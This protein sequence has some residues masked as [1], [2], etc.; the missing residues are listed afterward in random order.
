[1][2]RVVAL[3]AVLFLAA[4]V[5]FLPVALEDLDSV[6][7]A[8]GVRDFDVAQH[9]PHPPGYPAFIALAK[10]STA[11][12]SAAGVAMPDVRGLALLSAIAGALLIP[13]I[14]VF[15]RAVDG[16]ELRSV[17]TTILA[18]CAP[19]VWFNAVRPL[20]DMAG[21]AAAFA[22]LAALGPAIA[23]RPGTLPPSPALLIAGAFLAGLA[24]GFRSQMCLL[25]V[26][27]LIYGIVRQR[28]HRTGMIAAAIAGVL[29][30]GVPLVMLNGGPAGYL[31][32]LGSQAGED[33]S[34]VVMLWTNPSPR[35]AV[36]A[37]LHT[38]VRPWDA[39]WLAGV[40]LSLGAAGVLVLLRRRPRTFAILML[41]FGPYAVFHLLFQE[42][43]T[44]RYA[45][46]LVPLLACLAA[47]AIAESRTPVALGTVSVLAV[48]SLSFAMPAATA[49][50]K[51]P[52]PVFGLL[53]EAQMLHARGAAP[54]VGMHRRVFTESRRA[55]TYAGDPP[56][57]L[58]PTPRDYEWLE[59]TRSWREG[60]A[61]SE[62]WFFA[63][64][65]RTDLALVDSAHARVREYRWPFNEATYVGGARPSAIDWHVLTRP[66]WFLEQGWALTP[67]TAGIAD[68]DGWGP[69]RKPS[70]GWIRRRAAE[71]VMVIGGRHLGADPPVRLTASID[72][73]AVATLEVKP[74]YFLEFITVPAGELLGTGAYAPL[75]VTAEASGAEAS[76]PVSI[77]QFDFQTSD[78][79]LFGYDEGWF[80]P[81]FNPRTAR[82]WRWTSERATVRIHHAGRNVTLRFAGESP[83]RYFDQP[84]LVR[85][86]AGDRVLAELRPAA[87]FTVDVPIPADA[88][89][90]AQGRI[91]ITTDRAFVAGERTGT[92][93]RRRLSLRVYSLSVQ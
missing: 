10:A 19:L 88:L 47:A 23:L 54:I 9:Q 6:N 86:T 35:V 77:E 3:L 30:W 18:A 89:T 65:Q 48:V 63:D 57:Q 29:A 39:P 13:L 62:A 73:R 21:L 40:M 27:V 12:L 80:E 22:A 38:F 59:L 66:G 64:P 85:V 42:T 58:L 60:H 41:T 84:P 76:P 1:V 31:R 92:A 20:S 67:E 11:A 81:E 46:P 93:D 83:L 26:P 44:T 55:R 8:M 24:G 5:P 32:A 68:R 71:S 53:S 52:S 70:V 72:A 87:D 7:F 78:S 82:S 2:R 33:F 61:D 17:I 45:L 28:R 56:G 75:T 14:F 51:H 37:V 91:T 69:H 15:V 4:H 43:V 90:A 49:F 16:D 50:A 25:T 34:G 36:F 79:V 74:G